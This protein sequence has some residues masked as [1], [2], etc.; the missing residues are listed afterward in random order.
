MFLLKKDNNSVGVK[1]FYTGSTEIKPKNISVDENRTD[2]QY[3]FCK[4]PS[5]EFLTGINTFLSL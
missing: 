1:R 2:I 5:L 3:M 4:L